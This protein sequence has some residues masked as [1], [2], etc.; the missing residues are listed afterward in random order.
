MPT[1]VAAPH[2]L[3]S[4]DVRFR[5]DHTGEFNVTT[6]W[7]PC[8]VVVIVVGIVVVV[9][10]VVVVVVFVV[11]GVVAIVSIMSTYH[12][13]THTGLV[14]YCVESCRRVACVWL[15]ARV[16]EVVANDACV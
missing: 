2:V 16:L 9:V 3:R 1:A 14:P 4:H 6:C 5:H 8:V 12:T 13:H 7:S 10:F 15:H 11:L